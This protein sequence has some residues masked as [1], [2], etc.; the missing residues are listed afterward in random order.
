MEGLLS[1]GPTPL[2]YITVNFIIAVII[3]VVITV[4][5]IITVIMVI[6]LTTVITVLNANTASTVISGKFDKSNISLKAIKPWKADR[7][8][9]N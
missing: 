9:N 5:T 2:S 6:T 8:C 1:T 4:I 7:Y 3:D